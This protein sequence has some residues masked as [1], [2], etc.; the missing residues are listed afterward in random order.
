MTEQPPQEAVAVSRADRSSDREQSDA[1]QA[2]TVAALDRLAKSSDALTVQ[3]DDLAD[4]ARAE[5]FAA[6]AQRR[7]FMWFMGIM[8]VVVA[9]SL[10][11][12]YIQTSKS[13]DVLSGTKAAR[14]SQH[15]LSNEIKDCVEPTGQCY[16]DSQ[17]RTAAV[18]AALNLGTKVAAALAA[19]CAP[20]YVHLP[21]HQRI[22]AIE[23]CIQ[24]NAPH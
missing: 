16:K 3:A 24:R 18:V 14:A 10:I 2:V 15:R 7:R 9:I 23:A 8:A 17:A 22:N 20:D 21:L 12:L 1:D 6:S 11:G 4:A 13:N 19:A 5:L